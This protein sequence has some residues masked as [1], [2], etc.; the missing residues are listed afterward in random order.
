M[1][2]Q[3]SKLLFTVLCLSLIVLAVGIAVELVHARS[4]GSGLHD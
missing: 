4:F 1:K 3:L 2:Y